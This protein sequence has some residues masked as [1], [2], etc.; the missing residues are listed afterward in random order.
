MEKKLIVVRGGGDIATGTIHRL[1]SAGFP[2]LVLETEHPAAIRRQVSIC[3]AV[4]DGET[5]VENMKGI[6]AENLIEVR[7]IMNAG[8]VPV[9]IDPEGKSIQKLCPSV[10][11]DAILAKK[12]LGTHKEMAPLTVALG[13]GFDAGKDV[14]IVIET[15]RGH[16]LGRIIRL[17]SAIPNT[18][19]PGNI[20]GYT[21]ERVLYAE[22][23]GIFHNVCKIGDVVAAGQEIAQVKKP[24][25]EI[26]PVE[27]K[28]SGVLRGMLREGYVIT[29]GFKVADIDPR[30]EELENCFTISDKARCIAGSVLE[31]VIAELYK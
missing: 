26:C 12:N 21:A 5:C 15:M 10:V 24:D 11:V 30:I 31:V 29:K 20:K 4:Y 25:G 1:W 19:I 18:G 27:A 9:L 2:V 6:R 23:A 3:E 16:N 8:Q 7:N 28:I 22:K 13:P 14:D 17:G